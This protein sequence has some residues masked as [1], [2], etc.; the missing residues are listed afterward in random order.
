M[1]RLRDSLNPAA[2]RAAGTDVNLKAV[3]VLGG[4]LIFVVLLTAVT[5][6]VPIVARSGFS[7]FTGGAAALSIFFCCIGVG[8]MLIEISQMQRLI[9]LLGHPT[10]SL[11]V[12]LFALLVS[13]G[14]GSATTR[15]V[16]SSKALF[17]LVPLVVVLSIVSLCTP[18]LTPMFQAQS[19]PVRIM[20]ALAVLL[21]AGFFMGMAFPLGMKRATEQNAAL[22]PWLWGVNGATSVCASVLAVVIAMAWGINAASWMGVG[23]YVVAAVAIGLNSGKHSTSRLSLARKGDGLASDEAHV[24]IAANLEQ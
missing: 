14:L 15:D 6:V 19:T 18:Y 16:P 7:T 13:S 3:S 9:V 21:P 2:W 22:T 17:R 12:V 24:S 1:A 10:Y 20:A 11:S 8:F 4:L 23:C 5:I